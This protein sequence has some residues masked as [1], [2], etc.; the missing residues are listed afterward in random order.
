V[1]RRFFAPALVSAHLPGEETTGLGNYRRSTVRHVHIHT[2]C[3]RPHPVRGRLSWELRHVDGRVLRRAG[4]SG[5]LSPSEAR[6]HHTLDLA[7]DLARHGPAN[8]YLRIGLEVDGV[9]VSEDSVLLTA[10][11]FMNLPRGTR[12]RVTAR[13]VSP[14]RVQLT[15]RSEVFQHRFAFDLPGIAH[16]ASDNW[17]E[18]FPDEPKIVTLDLAAPQTRAAV[19]KALRWRSLADTY[20]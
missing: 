8:L 17:F 3:D 11:R 13:R 16:M 1:A 6:R 10:P 7:R 18:L 20:E 9:V 5:R 14:T 4:R 2:I 12:T 15:F 19:L